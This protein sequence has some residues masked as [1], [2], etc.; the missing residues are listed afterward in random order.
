[1]IK[2]GYMSMYSYSHLGIKMFEISLLRK[3]N[4]GIASNYI[5]Y[6]LIV[7]NTSYI[8]QIELLI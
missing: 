8:N 5:R 7:S 3:R 6:K 1:M 2:I 4:K